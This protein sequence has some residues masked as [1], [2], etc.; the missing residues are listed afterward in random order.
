MPAQAIYQALNPLTG[1]AVRR[2]QVTSRT[3]TA[4]IRAD[5]AFDQ[6][7]RLQLCTDDRRGSDGRGIAVLRDLPAWRPERGAPLFVCP[8]EADPGHDAAVERHL[9]PG[10]G[11][12]GA[13]SP[14]PRCS[15]PARPGWVATPVFG[16][17]GA[18]ACQPDQTSPLR[19]LATATCSARWPK[20]RPPG[21]DLG[22]LLARV[23]APGPK[24][25]A[26]AEFVPDEVPGPGARFL[27][28]RLSSDV[29]VLASRVERAG[30]PA[31]R[32]G[33]GTGTLSRG[34]AGFSRHAIGQCR[35]E[36]GTCTLWKT[37]VRRP[38][39]RTGLLSQ[40]PK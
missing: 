13:M 32:R 8:G 28:P 40:M 16:A 33:R 27:L 1:Q 26:W 25:P 31:G 34:V 38:T 18:Y 6:L 21:L 14:L 3:A 15:S 35:A 17:P 30:P 2:Y 37:L 23:L 5:E 39:A 24:F 19:A 12:V 22:I 10:G 29:R 9:A 4:V 11:G 36:I 20:P 7:V